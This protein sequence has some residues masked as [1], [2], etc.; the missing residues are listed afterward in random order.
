LTPKYERFELSLTLNVTSCHNSMMAL[1][2]AELSRAIF[3][4][5]TSWSD[6]RYDFASELV[7]EGMRKIVE[8]SIRTLV[9]HLLMEKY[10]RN[11]M[12]QTSENGGTNKSVLEAEVLLKDLW[13]SVEPSKAEIKIAPEEE[14]W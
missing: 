12:V 2:D 4:R 7:Q 14:K 11:T 9:E 6:G 13:V 5:F 10:G 1:D 3:N 8:Q